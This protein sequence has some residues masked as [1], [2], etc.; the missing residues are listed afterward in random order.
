MRRRTFIEWVQQELNEA[1]LGF[2]PRQ[3]LD[4]WKGD[5]SKGLGA[6]ATDSEIATGDYQ[7]IF[8]FM[9]YRWART[10]EKSAN[11][12]KMKD[13]IDE[14]AHYLGRIGHSTKEVNRIATQAITDAWG[15]FIRA[16]KG[17]KTS[18]MADLERHQ[19]DR[20]WRA[21]KD[22]WVDQPDLGIEGVD[23]VT[24]QLFDPSADDSMAA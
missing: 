24:W 1:D 2:D 8:D 18:R 14:F 21:M 4:I 9:A 12:E 13:A 23:D 20:V 3:A 19:H 10:S 16:T 17:R 7:M 15:S 5:T 6:F 22:V 11:K